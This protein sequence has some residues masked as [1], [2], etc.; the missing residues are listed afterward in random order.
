[1]A[2]IPL[3]ALEEAAESAAAAEDGR[4]EAR[5]LGQQLAQLRAALTPESSPGGGGGGGRSSSGGEVGTPG[6]GEG[7]PQ[8]YLPEE[9][10]P[11]FHSP[12]AATL[13]F[14][15][16]P[17][18]GGGSPPASPGLAEGGAFDFFNPGPAASPNAAALG[19][20]EGLGGIG[21]PFP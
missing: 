15:G 10:G 20:E 19:R 12:F 14:P 16:T 2:W 13:T 3:S 8:G 1:M 17:L 4:R 21:G 9:K 11:A 6:P 5:L 7:G 18:S